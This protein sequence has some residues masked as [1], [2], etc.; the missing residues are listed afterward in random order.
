MTKVQTNSRLLSLDVLR[1]ITILLS[2]IFVPDA[3]GGSISLKGF[4]YGVCLQPW[5]GDYFGSLLFVLLFVGLS[6]LIG[7]ILYKKQIYVKI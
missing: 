1:G 3:G 6:W 2:N 7:N 5:A 4:L